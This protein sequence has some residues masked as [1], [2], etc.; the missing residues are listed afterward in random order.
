MHSASGCPLRPDVL[1]RARRGPGDEADAREF[2]AVVAVFAL[3]TGLLIPILTLPNLPFLLGLLG[4]TGDLAATADGYLW[5][6]LFS[7]V[8]S[9]LAMTSVAVIRSYGDGRFAMY[10][11]LVG[12]RVNVVMDPILIFALGWGLKGVAW[13]TV[14][15]RL[16]TLIWALH[17][18]HKKYNAF[19]RV[20]PACMRRVFRMVSEIAFPT[21]LATICH[22][23]AHLDQLLART[24]G[25]GGWTG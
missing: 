6:I 14:L 8:F 17:V 4:A 16:A 10:P 12:A 20:G 3:F 25:Q 2:A 24:L 15:A 5:I 18:A 21:V 9:G 7:A 1:W 22:F 23:R 13:A 19:I 11:A